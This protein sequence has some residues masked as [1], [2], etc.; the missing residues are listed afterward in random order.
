MNVVLLLLNVLFVQWDS[1]TQ[2]IPTFSRA[3]VPPRF[4]SIHV[5]GS[6]FHLLTC[7]NNFCSSEHFYSRPIS[8]ICISACSSILQ[9]FHGRENYRFAVIFSVL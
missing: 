1:G 9:Q 8:I 2:D 5:K 4:T 6:Q 7:W 3:H